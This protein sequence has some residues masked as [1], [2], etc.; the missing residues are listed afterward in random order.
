MTKKM[1]SLAALALVACMGLAGCDDP[2]SGNQD[3]FS[4]YPQVRMNSYWLQQHTDVQRPIITR[5]GAGQIN[6][7]IPIR[8]KD[9]AELIIDY[10]YRFL[11]KAGAEVE[12]RSGWHNLRIPRKGVATIQFTSMTAMA[13]DFDVQI[14][15]RK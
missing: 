2:I 14:R 1:L 3:T 10:Q 11:T 7:Q 12:S 15:Y 13:D 8:N 9:D 5:V 4:E 6:V